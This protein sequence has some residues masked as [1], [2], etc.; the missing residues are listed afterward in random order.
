MGVTLDVPWPVLVAARD[1]WDAAGREVGGAWRRLARAATAG[2]SPA[3][4]AAVEGFREP[5]ADELR[6]AG[7]QADRHAEAFLLLRRGFG[8]TDVAQAHRLR[9]LLPW[10]EV[11]P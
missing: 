5:W 4:T 10:S 7:E 8:V 2:L 1:H 3:V 11:R 6:A 9:A